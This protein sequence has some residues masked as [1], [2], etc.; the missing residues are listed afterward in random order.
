MN[1]PV[2]TK[3]GSISQSAKPRSAKKGD[4][5]SETCYDIVLYKD[6]LPL[7]VT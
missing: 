1:V 2:P 4:D 5:S 7:L 3:K 6:D